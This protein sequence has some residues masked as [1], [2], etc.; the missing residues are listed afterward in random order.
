M[1]ADQHKCLP[2]H[3]AFILKIAVNSNDL[4]IWKKLSISL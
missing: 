2:L 4:E 3:A 1:R